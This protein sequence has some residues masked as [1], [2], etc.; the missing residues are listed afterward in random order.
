MKVDILKIDRSFVEQ[1]D[2]SDR[3][4]AIVAAVTAMSHA[5]GI[6]VVGEGVETDHQLGALAGLDC[7]QGQGFLLARPMSAEAVVALVV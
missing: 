4:R 2:T 5:L 7:D 6:S 1:I 3:D